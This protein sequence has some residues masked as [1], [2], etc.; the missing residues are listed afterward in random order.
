VDDPEEQVRDSVVDATSNLGS[1]EGLRALLTNPDKQIRRLVIQ[2]LG[3]GPFGDAAII[4]VLE[5]AL[6]DPVSDNS[7][8]AATVLSKFSRRALPVLPSLVR[9]ARNSPSQG[10]RNA[11]IATLG[12]IG[13]ESYPCITGLLNDPDRE[14]A[15][16]AG[17]WKISLEARYP[18]LRRP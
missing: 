3:Y 18:S 10:T 9:A 14:V 13:P 7:Q 15:D 17:K 4:P 12:E 1:L 16:Y 5:S 8:E 11:A 6:D 2:R